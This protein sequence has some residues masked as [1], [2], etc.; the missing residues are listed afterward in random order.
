MNALQ[1]RAPKPKFKDISFVIFLAQNGVW[2]WMVQV[3]HFACLWQHKHY[4]GEAR[5]AHMKVGVL[6]QE[7]ELDDRKRSRNRRGISSDVE[8]SIGWMDA[9]YAAYW[10]TMRLDECKQGELK[11]ITAKMVYGQCSGRA[12]ERSGCTMDAKVAVLSAVSAVA[13]LWWRLLLDHRTCNCWMSHNHL[14]LKI[15]CWIE[16]LLQNTGTVVAITLM[17]VFSG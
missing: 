16:R 3:I 2:V 14:V 5:R 8:S 12:V 10:R 1:N 9:I 11:L 7:P 15:H 13:C 17:I 6:P 4:I